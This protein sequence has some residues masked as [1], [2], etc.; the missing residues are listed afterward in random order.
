MLDFHFLNQCKT[1]FSW[2]HESRAFDVFF[3]NFCL[4]KEMKHFLPCFFFVRYVFGHCQWLC[5]KNSVGFVVLLWSFRGDTLGNLNLILKIQQKSSVYA[6]SRS[7]YK[8]QSM[9][10]CLPPW[11]RS[12]L[13]LTTIS[14]HQN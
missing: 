8:E 11:S 9:F 4:V 7:R 1:F 10:F 2:K 5:V 6:L 3:I 14:E 12:L 13:Y